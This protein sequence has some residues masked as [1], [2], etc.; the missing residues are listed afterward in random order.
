MA[1]GDRDL[2]SAIDELYALPP[3][4]FVEARTALARERRAAGDRD[5]AARVAELR[6]PTAPAWTLNQLAR[7]DRPGID[8]LVEAGEELARA[9]RKAMAGGR[10]AGLQEATARRRQAVE[11]LVERAREILAGAGHAAAPADRVADTLM[12]MATD[13]ELTEAVR[14]GRL[15]REA[16]PPAGFGAIPGLELEE[17]PPPGGGREGRAAGRGGRGRTG[18]E[19]RAEGTDEV[20]VRRSARQDREQRAGERDAEA[21]RERA[22]ALDASAAEAEEEAGRLEGEADERERQAGQ[23]REEADRLQ[24]DAREARIRAEEAEREARLARRR[25]DRSR[26]DAGRA[27]SEADRARARLS[28]S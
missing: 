5:G 6:K 1:G 3:E 17:V 20:A 25:A 19:R 21:A 14:A 26:T 23:A 27:R 2:E 16:P 12:A 28:P 9:Q 8:A 22:E 15:E 18:T 11:H 10:R 13:A 24:R 7:R 4:G